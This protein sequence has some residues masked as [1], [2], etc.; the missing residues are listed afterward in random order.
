MAEVALIDGDTAYLQQPQTK[1]LSDGE[2]FWTTSGTF[3]SIPSGLFKTSETIQHGNV[4]KKMT[5]RTDE[6]IRF[7]DLICNEVIDQVNHFWK[8]KTQKRMKELG[9]LHKRGIIMYGPPGC[10]KTCTIQIIIEEIIRKGGIVIYSQ[11]ARH[12]IHWMSEIHKIEPDRKIVVLLEDFDTLVEDNENAWL[13]L[14]DGEYQGDGVIYLAT[15]NYI[16]A[17]DKRFINRPSRFDLLVGIPMLSAES[18]GV[19]FKHK[20]PKLEQ[21]ALDMYVGMT[22]GF[23]IAHIKEFIVAIECFAK[24]PDEAA[25]QIRGQIQL[26]DNA[27]KGLF[28][29]VDGETLDDDPKVIRRRRAKLLRK[30]RQSGGHSGA[31]IEF[32]DDP[33]DDEEDDSGFD[34]AYRD[35]ELEVTSSVVADEDD[36]RDSSD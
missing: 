26:A 2:L 13:A 30:Q 4:L 23:Q 29:D 22:E 17:F 24:T 8:D 25:N 3:G 16:N 18:R 15:T 6:L 5:I 35:G 1:W 11:K 28:I 34:E 20:L 19:Y 21:D 10:G 31:L 12:L 32:D 33:E 27:D 9:F 14:L 7:P 36:E